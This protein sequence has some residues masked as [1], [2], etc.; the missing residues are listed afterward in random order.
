MI[1]VTGSS[2]E[3]FA[4][5]VCVYREVAGCDFCLGISLADYLY[6]SLVEW[7]PFDYSENFAVSN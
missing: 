3:L 4:E 6:I 2:S 7:Q 5:G 1:G